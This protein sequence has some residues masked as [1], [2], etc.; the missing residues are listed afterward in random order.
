MI[1]ACLFWH[2]IFYIVEASVEFV[3]GFGGFRIRQMN[4]KLG[5]ISIEVIFNSLIVTYELTERCGVQWNSNVPSTELWWIPNNNLQLLDTADAIFIDCTESVRYEVNHFRAEPQ[6]PNQDCWQLR[7]V[8]LSIV[9]KVA[10]RSNKTKTV[11]T[12][13]W[14]VIKAGAQRYKLEFLCH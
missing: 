12:V 2:P 13:N 6:T 11:D 10:K 9:S 7:S 1:S 8:E 14:D 4:I 5:V 3:K